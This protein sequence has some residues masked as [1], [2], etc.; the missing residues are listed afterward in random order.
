M[1]NAATLQRVILDDFQPTLRLHVVHTSYIQTFL[2]CYSEKGLSKYFQSVLSEN[3][4]HLWL[5][6]INLETNNPQN[7]PLCCFFLLIQICLPLHVTHATQAATGKK[8]STPQGRTR[9]NQK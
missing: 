6:F 2:V 3:E 8:E 5:K 9:F 1:Q 7:H 4:T